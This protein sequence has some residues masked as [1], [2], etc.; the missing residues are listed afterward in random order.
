M[1]LFAFALSVP[2][3]KGKPGT[4]IPGS[5]PIRFDTGAKANV[6]ER[7]RMLKSDVPAHGLVCRALVVF[8]IDRIWIAFGC[9]MDPYGFHMVAYGPHMNPSGSQIFPL[10]V[11]IDS[12]QSAYGSIWISHGPFRD[13]YQFHVDSH[14]SDVEC[15]CIQMDAL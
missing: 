12:M 14:R 3:T 5:L 13:P 9:H 6:L 2:N 8:H 4:S 11:H 1:D 15:I 10:W 7:K